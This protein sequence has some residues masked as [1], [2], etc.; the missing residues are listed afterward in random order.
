VNGPA[1]RVLLLADTH[2]V[3]DPRIAELAQDC[4]LAVHAGDVGASAVLE[5]LAVRG[6]NDV[7]GKWLGPAADLL[8]LP[9]CIE[10]PL[11]GGTLVV[12]HGH[13]H[14]AT[15][16]HLRLR[17]AYP[18]ARAVL[19]GH[20]HRLLQECAAAPWILNPGAAGRARTGGGPS[21]LLLDAGAAAWRVSVWQFPALPRGAR[22]LSE[23]GTKR[24]PIPRPCVGG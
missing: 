23:H 19:Y 16:R 7:P 24:P 18:G 2:G 3:L 4:A 22:G 12:E 1:V 6:N 15:R 5:A 17:A 11:P 13:R 8:A 14:S 21:C 10:V 9:E 20:S